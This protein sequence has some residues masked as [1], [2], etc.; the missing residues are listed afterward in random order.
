MFLFSLQYWMFT[1]LKHPLINSSYWLCFLLSQRFLHSFCSRPFFIWCFIYL[2]RVNVRRRLPCFHQHLVLSA[3]PGAW[4]Q[5]GKTQTSLPV[6]GALSTWTADL[7]P[8]RPGL[9]LGC[10]LRAPFPMSV[11]IHSK[12]RAVREGPSPCALSHKKMWWHPVNP[13]ESENTSLHILVTH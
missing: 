10:S 5:A 6:P 7:G 3:G 2:F 11:F 13:Q 12:I 4:R 1:F 8:C 9:S